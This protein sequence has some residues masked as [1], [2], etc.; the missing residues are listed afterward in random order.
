MANMANIASPQYYIER[1]FCNLYLLILW[2]NTF[3]YY[4]SYHI[5]YDKTE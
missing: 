5:F 3:H 4:I 1:E 2:T